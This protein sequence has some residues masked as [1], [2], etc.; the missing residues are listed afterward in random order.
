MQFSEDLFLQ[1]LSLW[2]DEDVGEGD[3][4]SLASINSN[5]I[6]HSTMLLKANG[7]IAG[8]RIAQMVLNYVD[9]SLIFHPFVKDGEY[10]ENGRVLAEASGSIQSLLK[11][12]RLMLNL[13]Q[14]L[15]GIASQTKEFVDAV[16]GTKCKI[17]DTRKTTPG[18]RDLEKWAVFIGG[19]ENHR[20]GLYDMI[21]LKD[22]H[23]DSAGGITAA[24]KRTR[25]F[26]KTNNK[27][28]RIEVETRNMAEVKEALG[29]KVDRIMLDNFSPEGCR[30][31]CALI[32]DEVETEASGGINIQ[33][34]KEYA[35]SGVNYISVGA[36]TH[37]VNALDISFKT[38]LKA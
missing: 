21:M 5:S 27:D 19:G 11:A 23:I 15:S 16:K 8:V 7:V 20:M 26:L 37:S 36:L 13:I 12:E 35:D 32:K 29:L 9:S 18:L 14:H 17:L 28:L 6:G 4:S 34:V 3:F 30:V 2:L 1:N 22:N 24:V 38:K 31:A 33:N 10:C 25:E